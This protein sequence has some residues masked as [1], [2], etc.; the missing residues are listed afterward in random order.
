M[1][2]PTDEALVILAQAGDKTA[3]G[4]LV[5][6]YQAMVMSL[7]LRMVADESSAQDLVQ[8]ALLQAYLSL[9]SLRDPN[10]FPSWLYGVVRNVCGTYR[11]EQRAK[12]RWLDTGP[13]PPDLYVADD[14]VG[15]EELLQ[16]HEW[17]GFV[18][19]QI[20]TLAAQ[21]RRVVLLF[22]YGQL[23]VREIAA[24]LDLS[25]S[26]VKNRLY[27]SR[28][29][30]K[31]QLAQLDRVTSTAEATP[32]VLE[33]AP[34]TIMQRRQPMVNITSV[35]IV[36]T[37]ETEHYIVFLLD[38]PGRRVLPLWV[39]AMEGIQILLQL[40]QVSPVRPWAFTLMHNLLNTLGAT[41]SA[42]QIQRL[43]DE[44]F[45]AVIQVHDGNT[46][47][48][49]EARPSDAIA[50]AL[51][52]QSPIA[53]AEEVMAVAAATLPEP[54][55]EQAWRQQEA[56]PLA[57]L[58]K[59]YGLVDEWKNK[60]AN[61]RFT[62]RAQRAWEQAQSEAQ[63][64][65]HASIDTEHLLLGIVLDEDSAGAEVLRNLGIAKDQIV[66][67]VERTVERDAARQAQPSAHPPMV[68][69]STQKVLALAADE[70]RVLGHR[71]L[72]TEHLLLG[73]VREDKST[74]ARLLRELGLNLNQVRP[75][76]I[77]FFIQ[78]MRR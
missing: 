14:A 24:Q 74:A 26:A 76:I 67:A 37:Q 18:L 41:V 7:A 71:Y 69:P 68:A 59:I 45:Y 33:Q 6:R 5:D 10:R 48:E 19:E 63:R 61:E 40:R 58:E 55:N 17:N 57:E 31:R 77:E 36:Q 62:K 34:K 4:H 25:V 2:P 52:T 20:N 3:F 44:T 50:L 72:G 70:R 64:L 43:K 56:Y 32:P 35:H 73:I 29:Q 42:V 46:T 1:L 65:N 23:S 53:V 21:N 12:W 15:P 13:L 39:G 30:L 28:Q 78:Q 66:A 75:Q 11:R 8:E 16:R 9:P 47:H 49:L 54:F 60:A 27:K 22:Y 51:H 38:Q